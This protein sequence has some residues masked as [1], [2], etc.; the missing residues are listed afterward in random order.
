RFSMTCM[1]QASEFCKMVNAFL[2]TG[3]K[4]EVTFDDGRCQKCGRPIC[5]DTKECQFCAKGSDVFN[6][7]F[8]MFKPYY[9][10]VIKIS[11]LLLFA[12]GMTILTP[13][14]QG[15][16]IDDYFANLQNVGYKNAFH[17]LLTAVLILL[18]VYLGGVALGMI[19]SVMTAKTGC[20]FSHEMRYRL[21]EKIEKMSVSS[22]AKH[23]TGELIHR[24]TRDTEFV[25]NM[26]VGDGSKLLEK[27]V[28]FIVVLIILISINPLLT[29]LVLAPIPVAVV[30]FAKTNDTMR[31]N[32]LLLWKT[33]AKETSVLNAVIRGLRVVKVF[34]NEDS[35]IEKYSGVSGNFCKM[36]I[37]NGRFWALFVEPVS[38]V[39]SIG[40]ILVLLVGGKMV[41]DGKITL[42][43]FVSFNLYLAYI[44][45]PLKWMSGLPRRL[46]QA[47]TS[48]VKIFDILDEKEDQPNF[49]NSNKQVKP[50][51]IVFE[52]V[53]FGYKS[54]EPVLKNIDLKIKEGEMIGLVGH[55][56][57][58]KSTMINMIIRLFDPN[59]GRITLG[60]IDLKDFDQQSYRGKIGVV[61]QDTYLFAGTIL[62]NITY[63]D[64]DAS[65]QAVISAAKVA[66][67]HDFIMNLPDGYNTIIGENGYRLSGG[68]RQRIAIARAVLRD[69]QILILDEATSALDPETEEQIQ[70]ALG[71]IV[72][73]RTTVAIAHRLSTL[74]HA[75]RLVVIEN[76]EIAEEGS[77]IELL[78]KRGIYYDLVMAQRRLSGKE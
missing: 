66:N 3:E 59:N 60:G 21:F 55:S 11:L 75:D 25:M 51:D 20:A 23:T 15:R 68:E 73:G 12:T 70:Q 47:V 19:S 57:A 36:S 53:T 17:G 6:R 30:L 56:G 72:K 32:N 10:S 37:I 26:F 27:V 78:Q 2:E 41:L 49:E 13:L 50:G 61:Y 31:K 74:R 16:L 24:I 43:S 5:V 1:N 14:V 45:S 8:K 54:Y 9:L 58:G 38:F 7:A 34:G 77:H 33:G 76:G 71:R 48:L 46:S 18:G 69:P 29:L 64:A 40:E 28:T 35:E 67:A 62:E 65:M 4:Y 42:G 63:A 39:V 52:N 22:V 44:Y